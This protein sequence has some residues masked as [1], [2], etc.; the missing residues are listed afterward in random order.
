[1]GLMTKNLLEGGFLTESKVLKMLH[2][3]AIPGW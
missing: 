3:E 2:C 1:M